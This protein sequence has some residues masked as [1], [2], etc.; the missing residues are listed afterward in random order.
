MESR[1]C[2]RACPRLR[3]G[4]R[5][6]MYNFLH[7]SGNQA[8]APDNFCRGQCSCPGQVRWHAGWKMHRF[9]GL[10][11][12]MAYLSYLSEA[13]AMLREELGKGADLA[14]LASDTARWDAMVEKRSGAN[15]H[16]AQDLSLIHISEP[17]RP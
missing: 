17:T 13:V 16:K 1:Q 2:Q 7:K 11:W 4:I 12:G 3:Q 9:R 6:P 10:H 5:L 8:L 14:K 15:M